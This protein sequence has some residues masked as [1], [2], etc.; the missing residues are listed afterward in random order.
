MKPTFSKLIEDD[1]RMFMHAKK[2][3]LEKFDTLILIQMRA[4]LGYNIFLFYFVTIFK[5]NFYVNLSF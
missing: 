5:V 2:G 3:Y 4:I 1:F